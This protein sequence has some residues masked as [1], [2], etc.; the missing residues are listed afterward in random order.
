MAFSGISDPPASV[1]ILTEPFTTANS[2][3]QDSDLSVVPIAGISYAV[4]ATILVRSTSPAAAA[5]RVG[6]AWPSGCTDG[7]AEIV[8][9]D[10][11]G[12]TVHASG[13]VAA[14]FSVV[15]SS[16]PDSD[17]WPVTVRATFLAGEEASGSFRITLSS[18]DG[19]TEVSMR[20][21]SWISS[22]AMG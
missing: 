5:P 20:T 22:W 10:T 3:A 21:G 14:D 8:A 19:T 17:S 15:T 7:V 6:V 13:N 9:A 4:E 2:A 16:L 11:A 1:T 12:S 18:S